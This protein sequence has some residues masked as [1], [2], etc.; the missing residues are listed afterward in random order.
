[1]TWLADFKPGMIIYREGEAT[2]AAAVCADRVCR[3]RNTI[4][5]RRCKTEK[6]RRFIG[7]RGT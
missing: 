3:L 6:E 4:A 7:R 2:I 1:M 5:L